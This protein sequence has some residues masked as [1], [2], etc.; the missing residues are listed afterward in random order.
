MGCLP[1]S[2]R[3]CGGRR[4]PPYPSCPRRRASTS[5]T[6]TG[7]TMQAIPVCSPPSGTL[8]FYP[9]NHG[10]RFAPPV[11]TIVRPL[12]GRRRGTYR[13][14]SATRKA[15]ETSLL[16]LV[17]KLY[18]GTRLSAK[19]HFASPGHA[20]APLRKRCFRRKAVAWPP[21]SKSAP[22]LVSFVFNFLVRI[23][24]AG[25]PR[26]PIKCRTG[27]LARRSG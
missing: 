10:F 11:A 17:P 8:P 25:G 12:R 15:G 6:R 21:H 24:A 4:T 23:A 22:V 26:L 27:V 13:T 14:I 18:L 9:V 7:A 16:L 2:P 20:P 19:L 3:V 1:G 5:G